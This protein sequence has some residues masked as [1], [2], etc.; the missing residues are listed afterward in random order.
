M[1]PINPG[2]CD[3]GLNRGR[4]LESWQ[5][6]GDP[7]GRFKMSYLLGLVTHSIRIHGMF[8]RV[9]IKA[10]PDTITGIYKATCWSLKSEF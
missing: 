7:I 2:V 1:T 8:S 3:R 4:G 10:L 9:I 6:V 5:V